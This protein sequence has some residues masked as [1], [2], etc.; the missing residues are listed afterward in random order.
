MEK[1]ITNIISALSLHE[2]TLL[3]DDIIEQFGVNWTELWLSKSTHWAGQ[4]DAGHFYSDKWLYYAP[5]PSSLN[6]CMSAQSESRRP[7]ASAANKDTRSQGQYGPY[8]K[9]PNPGR[10]RKRRCL[11]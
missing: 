2:L 10:N 9:W 6:S 11:M 1:P 5:F 7:D 4:V 3:R 8:A